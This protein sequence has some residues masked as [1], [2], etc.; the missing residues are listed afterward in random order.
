LKCCK[1]RNV[2]QFFLLSL[3]SHLDSHFKPWVFQGLGVCHT[4][5]INILT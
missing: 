3:F 2:P 4:N 1:L 5:Q